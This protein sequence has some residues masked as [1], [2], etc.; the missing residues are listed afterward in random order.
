[1]RFDLL[2]R[3]ALIAAV[4]GVSACG[5]GSSDQATA[6]PQTATVSLVARDAPAAGS[7]IVSFQIQI[8]DAVLQP[9]NVHLIH[10]PMTVDLAQLVTDTAFLAS[11]VI[12]SGTYTSLDLS[13]ANPQ[14]TL[15]NNTGQTIDTPNQECA[16]GATCTFAPSLTQAT[17]SISS[18][19]F[20]IT[21]AAGSGS[22]LQIDLS[23][24]DLL[25]SDLTISFANGQSVDLA[26]LQGTK[27]SSIDGVLASVE[28]VSGS[29]VTVRTAYDS[30][31]VLGTDGSTQLLFP[32]APCAAQNLSCLTPGTIV[33]ADADLTG[34]GALQV[35]RMSVIGAAGSTVVEGMVQSV[36]NASSPSSLQLVVHQVVPAGSGVSRGDV[37]AVALASGAVL[38]V[39][40][41]S[42]YPAVQQGA[43]AMPG[44]LA[45][46]QEVLALVS[47]VVA[48]QPALGFSSDALMLAP[49]QLAGVV[50]SVS[51]GSGFTMAGLASYFDAA[52]PAVT[53]VDVQ[54]GAATEYSG[55]TSD[56]LAT[57]QLVAVKGPLFKAVAG[58][59][60]QLGAIKVRG[61]STKQ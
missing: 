6:Q 23:I 48:Q 58:A 15:V 13:F 29:Q 41:T 3:S 12:G 7:S 39:D 37:A 61:W 57:Q 30:T 43:F 55:V 31:L 9:G 35:R 51:A 24:P 25:Q 46:G 54:T 34:A 49:S 56:T 16:P 22:G 44:D 20:P 50:Q 33:K 19:V 14:V 52:S 38:S 18:G 2:M 42:P 40:Q 32:A 8:T 11:S 10:N 26:F 4:V 45:A 59:N 47:G 1:M 27:L 17:I 36:D 53:A 60:P 5:G 21:L 28:S